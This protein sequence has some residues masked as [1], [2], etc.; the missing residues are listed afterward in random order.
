[1]ETLLA[2]VSN[3]TTTVLDVVGNVATEITEHPLLL[4]V[5]VG[6]P[7]VSFGTGL[8]IRIFHRA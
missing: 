7:V 4:L 5:A 2:G 6:L 8:L 1:M 3:V